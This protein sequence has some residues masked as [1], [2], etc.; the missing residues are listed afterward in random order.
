LRILRQQA[1]RRTEK[2]ARTQLA[3]AVSLAECGQPREA[4]LE[5]LTALATTRRNKDS[6]GERAAAALLARLSMKFGT[7]AAARPW[8]TT[9]RA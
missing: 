6:A 3:V 7:K 9:L 2:D 8:V 1:A 5:T 4:I